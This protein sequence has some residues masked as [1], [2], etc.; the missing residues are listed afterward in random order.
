MFQWM[1]ERNMSLSS[2]S[3]Q[4]LH[5]KGKAT[6]TTTIQQW[7]KEST[8]DQQ[9]ENGPRWISNNN[10]D[11]DKHGVPVPDTMFRILAKSS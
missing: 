5:A 10:G 3:S 8:E 9:V 7:A 4:Y 2:S 11:G 6:T 1:D